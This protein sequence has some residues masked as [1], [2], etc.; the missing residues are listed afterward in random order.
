M[1]FPVLDVAELA[2]RVPDGAQVALAKEPHVPMTL[3]RALIARQARD[4]HLVTVPTSGLAADALIGGGCVGTIE[5]S[6]VSLG[7]FGPA[8]FFGEAV[9]S[10]RVRIRDA[11]CPA[12]YAALQAGEKGVPF[13]PIRGVIGSDLLANREDWTVIDNPFAEGEDP[14]VA[15]KAIRPDFALLHVPEADRFGNA[16]VGARHEFKTMAH[17][18]H[19]TLITAERIV[20]GNLVEDPVKSANLVTA[21]Y[22]D[23]VAE[24]PGGAWPLAAPPDYGMDA[25]AVRAYRAAARDAAKGGDADWLAT[26]AP[27][28]REAA[29]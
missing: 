19:R 4:L 5:T 23:A 11:T 29:E 22:V 15:L 24:A 27:A 17:A 16:W 13:M 1:S 20:E 28:H 7:E 6:G 25:E 12:V 26:L 14:I 8:P 3:V 10:G 2:A 9:K 21:I 18:A